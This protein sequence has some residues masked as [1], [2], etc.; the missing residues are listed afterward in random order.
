MASART[1]APTRVG[2]LVRLDKSLWP[3]HWPALQ[4]TAQYSSGYATIPSNVQDGALR[5]IKMRYYGRQR[6]PMLRQENIPNVRE[7]AF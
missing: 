1:A 3:R 5:L 7:T 2:Q 6:D 4:I